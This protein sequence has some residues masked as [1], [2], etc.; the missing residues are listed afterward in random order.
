MRKFRLLFLMLLLVGSFS[1]FKANNGN[2]GGGGVEEEGGCP[3]FSRPNGCACC[4]DNQCASNYCPI[5]TSKCA[6]RP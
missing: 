3:K 6:D 1:T 2:C 4:S 5:S